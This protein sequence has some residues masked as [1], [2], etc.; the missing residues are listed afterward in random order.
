MRFD[1]VEMDVKAVKLSA[2][3]IEQGMK[4]DLTGKLL[5]T[6]SLDCLFPQN[7][8]GFMDAVCT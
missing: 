8:S 2:D 5:F 3:E 1:P 4:I 7:P 6:H